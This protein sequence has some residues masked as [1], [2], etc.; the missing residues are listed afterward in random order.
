MVLKIGSSEFGLCP[1]LLRGCVI[2]VKREGEVVRLQRFRMPVFYIMRTR[3]LHE[4]KR[5]RGF[6]MPEAYQR[7]KVIALNLF[8][9]T[10][11]PFSRGSVFSY[12][13]TAYK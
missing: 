3:R 11:S 4:M 7:L 13:D 9:P 5:F 10:T 6:G 8:R 12:Y 1:S 2:I